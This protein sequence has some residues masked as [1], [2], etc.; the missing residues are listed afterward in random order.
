[1][2]FFVNVYEHLDSVSGNWFYNFNETDNPFP[3]KFIAKP[4]LFY[5]FM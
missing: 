4:F 3:V 5:S 2:G 1:M